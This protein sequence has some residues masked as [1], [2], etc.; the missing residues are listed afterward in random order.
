MFSTIIAGGNA[1]GYRANQV[2]L[3]DGGAT[4]W[5]YGPALPYFTNGAPMVNDQRGGVVYVGGDVGGYNNLIY[6]LR[7]AK[8]QWE[9]LPSTIA[10]PRMWHAAF[11][12]QE[13]VVKCQPI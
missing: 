4:S 9:T 2:E 5:R 3:L 1:N 13:E 10:T 8:A 7:H 11:L 6:R 12:V